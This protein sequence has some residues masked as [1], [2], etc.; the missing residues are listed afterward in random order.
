MEYL[1]LAGVSF[2]VANKLLK[3][4]QSF[5]KDNKNYVN[6][7]IDSVDKKHVDPQILRQQSRYSNTIIGALVEGPV[8]GYAQPL[9]SFTNHHDVPA[10]QV[11]SFA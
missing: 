8:R 7:P 2:F 9:V 10:V 3:A 11:R 1:L 5:I 6:H 4:Q